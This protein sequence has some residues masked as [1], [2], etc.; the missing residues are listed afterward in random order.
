MLHLRGYHDVLAR[1]FI[2]ESRNR[3]NFGACFKKIRHWRH[4]HHL[5]EAPFM[6]GHHG[7][8]FSQNGYLFKINLRSK[9]PQE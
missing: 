3:S 1:V 2:D 4:K 6:D 8:H 7:W 5:L 9:F